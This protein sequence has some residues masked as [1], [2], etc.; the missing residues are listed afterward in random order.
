MPLWAYFFQFHI[1][2]SYFEAQRIGK[3]GY[4]YVNIHLWIDRDSV[5][6]C[7]SITKR[8]GQIE[9]C[10]KSWKCGTLFTDAHRLCYS[11][12]TVKCFSFS[13]SLRHRFL[14]FCHRKLW[15]DNGDAPGILILQVLRLYSAWRDA[16][17]PSIK[18]IKRILI[19]KLLKYKN[20]K[21]GGWSLTKI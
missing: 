1:S 6:E 9:F 5:R 2:E 19:I 4:F 10:H 20:V 11:H 21:I 13:H 12:V 7:L 18:K 8:K 15:R 14:S 16:L 3:S 17:H